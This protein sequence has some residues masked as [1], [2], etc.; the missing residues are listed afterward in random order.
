M[1]MSTCLHGPLLIPLIVVFIDKVNCR[2]SLLAAELV[3]DDV[4]YQAELG[5]GRKDSIHDG[6]AGE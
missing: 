1:L 2:R 4:C 5:A 6:C 3:F